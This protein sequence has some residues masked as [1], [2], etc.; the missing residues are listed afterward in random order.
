MAIAISP[1][2]TLSL[3][4]KSADVNPVLSTL[5]IAKSNEESLHNTLPLVLE[6]SLNNTLTST[7]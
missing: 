7:A 6:P 4:P 3:S 1:V 2:F 5:T